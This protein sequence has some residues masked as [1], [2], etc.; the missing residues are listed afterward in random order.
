[1]INS[2]YE[3]Q[4]VYVWVNESEM[5]KVREKKYVDYAADPR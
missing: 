4:T 3:P 2:R 1:M 5:K